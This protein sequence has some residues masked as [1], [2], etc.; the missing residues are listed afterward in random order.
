MV[1]LF[2]CPHGKW[3]A[4]IPFAGKRP[5]DVVHKPVSKSSFLRVLGNPINGVVQFNQPVTMRTGAD[6]PGIA[7]VIQQW[8]SAAPAERIGMSIRFFFEQQAAGLQVLNN[9]W[10]SIFDKLTAPR[11]HFRYKC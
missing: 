6:V 11:S 9:E 7:C 10:I 1:T 3:R 4:P 8:S 5:V 2:T